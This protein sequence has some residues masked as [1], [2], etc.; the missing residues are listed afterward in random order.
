VALEADSVSVRMWA[1]TST[2][3]TSAC[4]RFVGRGFQSYLFGM[5]AG[6]A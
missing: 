2:R 4:A 3:R 1:T 5:I 6:I